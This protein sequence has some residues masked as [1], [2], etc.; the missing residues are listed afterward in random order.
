ML[1][2][3]GHRGSMDAETVEAVALEFKI[4]RLVILLVVLAVTAVRPALAVVAVVWEMVT[5]A[6][7]AAKVREGRCV[8]G[9]FS[10]S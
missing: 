3:L 6:A 10:I 1:E 9:C 5:R 2:P 7:L 8:Y 4:R